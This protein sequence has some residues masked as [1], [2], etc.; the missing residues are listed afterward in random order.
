MRGYM[1]LLEAVV[2]G[3]IFLSLLILLQPIHEDVSPLLIFVYENDMVSVGL[4]KGESV[5]CKGERYDTFAN[6]VCK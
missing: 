1:L 4:E 6:P 3:L 5:S 2:A